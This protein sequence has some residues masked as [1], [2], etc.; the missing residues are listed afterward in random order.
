MR[1]L[2]LGVGAPEPGRA[3]GPRARGHVIVFSLGKTV[4]CP[5]DMISLALWAPGMLALH[6]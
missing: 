3:Q 4:I 2:A 6:E 5:C 1:P